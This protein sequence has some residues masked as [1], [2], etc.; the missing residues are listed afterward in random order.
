[1]QLPSKERVSELVTRLNAISKAAKELQA[2]VQQDPRV[3]V[4]AQV[5]MATMATRILAI[6]FELR[7][8]QSWY[9]TVPEHV[10]QN[11]LL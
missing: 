5:I 1:M 11:R 7:M 8:L 3:A 9:S 4:A 2:K 6:T 10:L